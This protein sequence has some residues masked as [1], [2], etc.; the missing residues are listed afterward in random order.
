M[1]IV[2]V[3]VAYNPKID[4]LINNIESYIDDLESLIIVNNSSYSLEEKI[5]KN[6]I[7][8]ENIKIINL[9]ENFG[10]AK[11]QNIGME[12]AF[13]NDIDFVIQMDQDSIFE[14]NAISE[15]IKSFENLKNS[16]INIGILGPSI[17]KYDNCKNKIKIERNIKI[18]KKIIEIKNKKYKKVKEVISSGTMISKEVYK[19]NGG[20][21]EELFIDYV[22]TEYCW[23]VKKNGFEIF[24]DLNTSLFHSLGSGKIKYKN[25]E[26]IVSAPIRNYY[27]TRNELYLL[28]YSYV[29]LNW[30]RD[31]IKRIIRRFFLFHKIMPDGELR[32]KYIRK[33]ISDFFLKKMGKIDV[34]F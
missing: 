21:K 2:G 11:A 27:Q 29:P 20:M 13:S 18:G 14:K 31:S 22:D 30:K 12:M 8:N 19:K 24:Q 15:L 7:K 32:K 6:Y 23:R 26:Y 28:K 17:E 3:L 34:E 10:I 5:Y 1:R 16:G 25:K 9:Y 4:T 33:G